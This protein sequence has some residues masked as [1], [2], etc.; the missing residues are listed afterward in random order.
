MAFGRLFTEDF[1][2]ECINASADWK[3]LDETLA[4]QHDA[5]RAIFKDFLVH[6][7]S[8]EA[9]TE[10]GSVGGMNR[11]T[12]DKYAV[13]Q[14]TKINCGTFGLR[15]RRNKSALSLGCRAHT[16]RLLLAKSSLFS[17]C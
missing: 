7:D 14:P 16:K 11:L 4:E 6:M 2:R 17:F 12:S 13:L 1:L 15:R 9:E 3:A 5:Q 8:N 10:A